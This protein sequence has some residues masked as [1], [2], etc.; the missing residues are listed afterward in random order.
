M[1]LVVYLPDRY[2]LNL[3]V[4]GI[5]TRTSKDWLGR[6]K[7]YDVVYTDKGQFVKIGDNY[8]RLPDRHTTQAEYDFT[9][10][11]GCWACHQGIKL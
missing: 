2:E 3:V 7:Q 8:Q 10:K 5:T 4:Y 11:C 6:T 1:K 9:S